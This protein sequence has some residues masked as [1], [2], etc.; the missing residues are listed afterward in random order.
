VCGKYLIKYYTALSAKNQDENRKNTPMR[1]NFPI[2]RRAG[3]NQIV[4]L[5]R[6][7]GFSLEKDPF[8]W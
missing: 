5:A 3:R 8:S 7:N 2:S 6:K 4:I 1:P